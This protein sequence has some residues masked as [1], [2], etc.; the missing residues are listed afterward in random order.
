MSILDN[1]QTGPPVYNYAGNNNTQS[2]IAP[3]QNNPTNTVNIHR[4]SNVEVVNVGRGSGMQQ[5][6][7]SQPINHPQK[8][9]QFK[10]SRA[11]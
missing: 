1:R 4:T 3:G 2:Y 6:V 8:S 11:A 7:T 10:G 9:S 5:V